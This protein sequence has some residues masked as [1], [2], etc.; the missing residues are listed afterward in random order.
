MLYFLPSIAVG[1]WKLKLKPRNE[2]AW[3]LPPALQWSMTP[4]KS[5]SFLAC[6]SASTTV[7]NKI[8]SLFKNNLN[9][10]QT[11]TGTKNEKGLF[12]C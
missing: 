9:N 7:K 11:V 10:D 8:S 6:T 3:V 1:H 2:K 12:V 5:W 4:S